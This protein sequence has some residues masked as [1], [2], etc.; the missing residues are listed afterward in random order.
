MID[1][2]VLDSDSSFIK[3]KKT[4]IQKKYKPTRSGTIELANYLSVYLLADCKEDECIRLL[5]SYCEESPFSEHHPERWAATVQ[6]ISLLSYLM[7]SHGNSLE[8]VRLKEK[9][10]EYPFDPV[11]GLGKEKYLLRLHESMD[12]NIMDICDITKMERCI[13][14]AEHYLAYIFGIVMKP[15]A[16]SY[17]LSQTGK[18]PEHEANKLLVKLRVG[19]CEVR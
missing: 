3:R 4:E 8:A 7:N 12:S 9:I 14:L 16:C 19:L 10:D 2:V 18:N 11:R 17:L 6:A 5:Q 13:I 15:E 1:V